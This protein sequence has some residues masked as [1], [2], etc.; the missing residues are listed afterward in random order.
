MPIIKYIVTINV[1]AWLSNATLRFFCLAE[2]CHTHESFINE[3]DLKN[4]HELKNEDN[5]K[6]KDDFKNEDDLK[7]EYNLKN[8]E[9]RENENDLK[10][11]NCPPPT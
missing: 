11:I 9:I 10:K 8:E 4:E 3:N 1:E 2:L 7:N 5:L 6:N